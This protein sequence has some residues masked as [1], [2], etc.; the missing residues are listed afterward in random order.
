MS[1]VGQ[2]YSR[3]ARWLL[4]STWYSSTKEKKAKQNRI[5]HKTTANERSQLCQQQVKWC[6]QV[7]LYF[8]LQWRIRIV[9][10]GG[11]ETNTV[12]CSWE[13]SNA[14]N[15]MRREY[16]GF[17]LCLETRAIFPRQLKKYKYWKTY[18]NRE[19]YKIIKSHKQQLN[20]PFLSTKYHQQNSPSVATDRNAKTGKND[21]IPKSHTPEWL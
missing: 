8:K 12:M 11:G 13:H 14:H 21:E 19:S 18:H 2:I 16:T 9:L 5:D 7:F 1:E 17:S 15:L 4:A 6:R 20:V 10:I 3:K